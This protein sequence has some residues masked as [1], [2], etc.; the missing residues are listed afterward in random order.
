MKNIQVHP[1][2][3]IT[4]ILLSLF[5]CYGIYQGIAILNDEAF[6][7]GFNTGTEVQKLLH[8]QRQ[9]Q[10][11]KPSDKNKTTKKDEILGI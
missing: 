11:G 10:P 4:I 5:I 1:V 9:K 7:R 6:Y 2:I 8:D 3:A